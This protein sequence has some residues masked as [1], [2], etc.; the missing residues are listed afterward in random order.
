MGI[1]GIHAD[2]VMEL[3]LKAVEE[4]LSSDECQVKLKRMDSTMS[5]LKTRRTKII[6][7]FLDDKIKEETYYD[8]IRD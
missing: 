6:D 1:G 7:L 5:S 8:G 2:D 3:V 4:T